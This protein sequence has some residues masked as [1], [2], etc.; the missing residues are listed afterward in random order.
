MIV[1]SFFNFQFYHAILTKKSSCIFAYLI[2]IQTIYGIV[3]IAQQKQVRGAWCARFTLRRVLCSTC[4]YYEMMIDQTDRRTL[5]QC[6]ELHLP[7][8]DI[9]SP[10]ANIIFQRLSVCDCLCSVMIQLRR[11]ISCACDTASKHFRTAKRASVGPDSTMMG[12]RRHN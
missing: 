10:L 6:R 12:H 8:T 7:K 11:L 1:L 4:L 3:V 5:K 9:V 2:P